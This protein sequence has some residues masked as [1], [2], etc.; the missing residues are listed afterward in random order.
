MRRFLLVLALALPLFSAHAEDGYR[1][2]L[3]YEKIGDEKL[4]A[5]QKREARIWRD[6]CT[7]YFAI[8]AKR[9][10]PAGV[11]P[12]R[13]PLEDLRKLPAPFSVR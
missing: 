3:R 5:G 7:Q 10:L 1:L 12:P 11:E 8:F 9:P 6:A 2:W 4:L 13:Y